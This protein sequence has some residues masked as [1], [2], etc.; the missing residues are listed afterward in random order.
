MLAKE[1]RLNLQKDFQVI[2]RK[3]KVFQL[4]GLIVRTKTNKLA[5]SRFGLV[6]GLKADKKAVARN[7][8]RRQLS[9]IIR[10]DLNNISPGFDVV[11][12]AQ[13]EIIGK[14]SVEIR[15]ILGEIFKKAGLINK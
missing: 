11:I 6:V 15:A 5:R 8:L 14:A 13:K 3:G 1:N 10:H 2:F 12:I 7:R 9:E 4:R